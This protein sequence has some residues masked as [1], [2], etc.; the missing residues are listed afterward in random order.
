LK[1]IILFI[2]S[3]STAEIKLLENYLELL[4]CNSRKASLLIFTSVEAKTKRRIKDNL[5]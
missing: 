2:S 3:N 4:H 1:K 5:I